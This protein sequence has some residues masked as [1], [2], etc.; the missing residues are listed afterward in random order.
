MFRGG[1]LYEYVRV[2]WGVIILL[3]KDVG[4]MGWVP[5]NDGRE[6]AQEAV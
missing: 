1:I 2:R 3:G 4:A 6:H 5:D